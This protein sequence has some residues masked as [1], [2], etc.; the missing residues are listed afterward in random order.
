MDG[1]PVAVREACAAQREPVVLP[2]G[3]NE[4]DSGVEIG[5][6]RIIQPVIYRPTD[7]RIGLVTDCIP[8]QGIAVVALIHTAPELATDQDAVVSAALASTP[9]VVV[10]QTDLRATVWVVQ[11]GRRV[12][13]LGEATLAAIR[14]A[15]RPRASQPVL[16]DIYSG[17][18]LRSVLDGRWAFKEAE[19]E[20]LRRLAIPLDELP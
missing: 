12:G 7:G 6:L 9:Y 2:S 20:A 3:R 10:V 17:I 11:L 4:P 16:A 18:R 8:Q 15:V 5:D 14:D 19:G 13:H 1:V